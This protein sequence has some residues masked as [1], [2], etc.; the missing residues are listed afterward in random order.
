MHWRGGRINT[1]RQAI[2]YHRLKKG[3]GKRREIRGRAKRVCACACMCACVHVCCMRVYV[4]VHV[5]E[6]LASCSSIIWFLW[7]TSGC[8][9]S[10][11]WTALSSHPTPG[12]GRNAHFTSGGCFDTC[13]G[14][15]LLYSELSAKRLGRG[16]IPDQW[17]GWCLPIVAKRR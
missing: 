5:Y 11:A 8:F 3:D 1:R 16:N 2:N 12:G 14:P 13:Q 7:R 6:V 17:M 15:G 10:S 4:C 9:F